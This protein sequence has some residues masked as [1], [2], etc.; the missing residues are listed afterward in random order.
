MDE[1]GIITMR[2]L[3]D[4]FQEFILAW[5]GASRTDRTP[6]QSMPFPAEVPL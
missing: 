2:K 5:Q 4:Y 3:M 6:P 1:V